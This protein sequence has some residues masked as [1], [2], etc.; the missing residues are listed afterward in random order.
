[1]AEENGQSRYVVMARYT[2][3]DEEG[4]ALAWRGWTLPRSSCRRARSARRS[5]RRRSRRLTSRLSVPTTRG[6]CSR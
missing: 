1:M 5:S 3:S 6:T 2:H 4:E